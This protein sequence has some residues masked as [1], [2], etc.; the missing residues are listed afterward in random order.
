MQ[1]IS[2]HADGAFS[3]T[4][5]LC[6][7]SCLGSNTE[8]T[9]SK[10]VTAI[11]SSRSLTAFQE[12]TSQTVTNFSGCVCT[13]GVH[14]AGQLSTHWV[15]L[16]FLLLKKAPTPHKRRLISELDNYLKSE[17]ILLFIRERESL[18]HHIS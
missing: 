5:Y 18:T 3:F 9:E 16:I 17:L 13:R 15:L 11:L 4:D 8:S 6:Q 1:K 2:V 10:L 7:N 14:E 12:Q